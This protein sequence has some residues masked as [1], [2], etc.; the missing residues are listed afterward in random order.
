MS[1][2]EIDKLLKILILSNGNRKTR[3]AIT[4]LGERKL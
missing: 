3:F 4:R 1:K 2:T